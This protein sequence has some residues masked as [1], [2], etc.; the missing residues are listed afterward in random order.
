MSPEYAARI[1]QEK[2]V[3]HLRQ[4]VLALTLRNEELEAA[5][6]ALQ[7][8]LAALQAQLGGLDPATQAAERK[9]LEERIALLTQRL[10]G[11][12]SERQRTSQGGGS[13]G[14]G[15]DGP[16]EKAKQTGHGPRPQ[17]TLERQVVRHDA[18]GGPPRC[19]HCGQAMVALGE[20]FDEVKEEITVIPRRFVLLEHRQT[21]YRC[22]LSERMV[23]A[24]APPLWLPGG[25]YSLP[26]AVEVASDKYGLHLPLERQRQAMR[27]AG[28][29]ITT[30]T[31][32]D[33]LEALAALLKPTY[34]GIWQRILAH[35]VVQADETR[36]PLLAHS[37]KEKKNETCYAWCVLGGLFVAYRILESRS[38]DAG[39]KVLGAYQGTVMA[40]GYEVYE[41]L[42]RGS[43]ATFHVAHCWA[44]ARRKFVELL[45]H[46][47]AIC[48]QAI[49]QIDALFR[50]ERTFKPLS[51]DERHRRRQ[52]ESAPLVDDFFAWAKLQLKAALPRS[53]IAGALGYVVNL[54]PGLRAFLTDPR[55][56][57]DNN[58]A[59]RAQR[60]LVLGRVNHY[61]SRSTKGTTIAAVCYTLIETAKLHDVDPKA[62]LLA[63]ANAALKNPNAVLLPG[64][65]K[66]ALPQP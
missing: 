2:D 53:S 9:R 34:E 64:D 11:R 23:T 20:R 14:A 32:A 10:Y 17:P 57:L 19:P 8:E 16:K 36:W 55:I 58:A 25:R 44:H 29:T 41:A 6:A 4:L 7:R 63:V 51:P 54:E 42:A 24:A 3:V 50:L 13:S 45:P 33:Q 47:P 22:P 60:G 61:G 43:P 46:E 35:E 38:Q 48:Q 37:G 31:L 66:A 28:L 62:Y 39:A 1:A 59:E 18:P 21:T 26:F 15:D 27:Q 5:N 30:A 52:A 65:F 12:H 56:P 40:D 49:A